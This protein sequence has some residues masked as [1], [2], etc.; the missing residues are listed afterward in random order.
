MVLSF[1][2]SLLAQP[3]VIKVRKRKSMSR[4]STHVIAKVDSR[5]RRAGDT[6]TRSSGDADADV[7]VSEIGNA[8]LDSDGLGEVPVLTGDGDAE[9]GLLLKACQSTFDKGFET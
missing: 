3:H 6:T 2:S 8:I 7:E 4:M 1:C 5:V 9:R